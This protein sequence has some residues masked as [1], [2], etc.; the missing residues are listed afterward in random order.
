MGVALIVGVVCAGL[1]MLIG[2]IGVVMC[3]LLLCMAGV[4]GGKR[5]D[6]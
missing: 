4:A 5:K 2:P 3:G 1:F 6:D